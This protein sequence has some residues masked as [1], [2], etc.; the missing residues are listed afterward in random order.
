MKSTL[1]RL[2]C[3]V[4]IEPNEAHSGNTIKTATAQKTQKSFVAGM[5]PW[6]QCKMQAI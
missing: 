5:H 6:P 1:R 3:Q 2:M 4:M